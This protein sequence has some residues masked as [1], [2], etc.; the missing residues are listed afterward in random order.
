MRVQNKLYAFMHVSNYIPTVR[1]GQGTRCQPHPQVILKYYSKVIN[2]LPV[3]EPEIDKI[4]Q[5]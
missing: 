3:S 5:C 4:V 1:Y 2:I